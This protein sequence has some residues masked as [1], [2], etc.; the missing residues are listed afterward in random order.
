MTFKRANCYTF[1]SYKGGSGRT[2]AL[3]NTAKQLADIL[4]ASPK[5]PILLVDADLE[6]AGLTYFF[7]C[8]NRF[9][10]KV[11][12]AIH[13]EAFLN[14]P[15]EFLGR[16][17]KITFGA[18][19]GSLVSC[20]KLAERLEA[21]YGKKTTLRNVRAVF[22]HVTID[23]PTQLTFDRLIKAL[24]REDDQTLNEDDR[25]DDAFFRSK[26][27]FETLF[28]RLEKI[29]KEGGRD[30]LL[31]KRQAI[32]DFLPTS[33]MVDVSEY[34]ALPAGTVRFIGVDVMFDG[35]H[36]CIDDQVAQRNMDMILKECGTQGFSAVLMDCSAGVQSTAH[37]LN[38]VSDVLV[39]C[40]RPTS[41]FISGT[42][43]QLERYNKALKDIATKKNAFAMDFG[44]PANMKSVIL[45]PTAVPDGNDGTEILKENSF[46]RIQ[47]LA[48]V[49]KEYVEDY[50]CSYETSLPEVS[51]FK[52][53]EHILGTSLCK[54]SRGKANNPAL[55]SAMAPY[56]A[57]VA[58]MPRDAQNAW[59]VYRK[60]A[61]KLVEHS[62]N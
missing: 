27:N 9:S 53:R 10:S 43:T 7:N 56:A 57:D 24:E 50:F 35:T 46:S 8:E 62:L 6:S 34:F 18:F 23:Y 19:E 49:F 13:S 22:E 60:L 29:G 17:Q 54:N 28:V 41:Q 44:M 45:L 32:E 36:A 2:T 37:V 47:A 55:E 14:T 12:G 5:N 52:W 59:S 4:K 58:Q 15:G 11:R 51:L 38:H 25:K 1:Y 3:L 16:F 21:Y 61:E 20:D 48:R 42:Q 31:R 39:Y 33:K 40:M 26:Y 30:M